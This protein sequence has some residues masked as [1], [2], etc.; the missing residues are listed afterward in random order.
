MK[1]CECV[2]TGKR[3]GGG[4]IAGSCMWF[5]CILVI[6]ECKIRGLCL[7]VYCLKP[8]CFLFSILRVEIHSCASIV[9]VVGVRVDLL[10]SLASLLREKISE[11]LKFMLLTD[12]LARCLMPV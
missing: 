6:F 12:D 5:D 8:S 10:K 2:S 11:T 4:T 3:A 9:P 7:A 1:L